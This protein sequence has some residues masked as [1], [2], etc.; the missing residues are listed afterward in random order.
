MNPIHTPHSKEKQGWVVKND[1]WKS[2][3]MSDVVKQTHTY[4]H[5]Y[6][7]AYIHTHIHIHTYTVASAKKRIGD[8]EMGTV[9]FR[10][11]DS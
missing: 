1:F 4:I 10:L 9:N 6:I 7:H 3:N 5:T 11:R 2:E 8:C